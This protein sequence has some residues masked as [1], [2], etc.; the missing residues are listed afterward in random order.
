MV[1]AIDFDSGRC[2]VDIIPFML[3]IAYRNILS[4]LLA[5]QKLMWLNTG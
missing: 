1:I 4:R 3:V 5:F 2:I